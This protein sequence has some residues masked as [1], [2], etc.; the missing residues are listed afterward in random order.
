MATFSAEW[1]KATDELLS[2]RGVPTKRRPWDAWGE[3]SKLA[4]PSR[5]DSPESQAIFEWYTEEYGRERFAIGSLFTGALYFDQAV[6][7]VYV[8]I[9]YGT[10]SVSINKMV[11]SMP[12]LIRDRMYRHAT[13]INNLVAVGA[14]CIDYGLGFDDL[15]GGPLPCTLAMEM[16]VSADKELRSS[17]EILLSDRPTQKAAE[18]ARL[19]TEMFLKCFLAHHAGA[20]AKS[21]RDD[22]RH[23][24]DKALARCLKQLPQSDLRV[25]RGQFG[26]F[27]EIGDRYAV[28]ERPLRDLWTCYSLAQFA[29]ACVVRSVTD[30]DVR[31]SISV[32]GE[33]WQ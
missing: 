4:G 11:D 2:R 33:P 23:R 1:I 5:M 21:L 14:D 13:A 15:R 28:R 30:R 24:L 19:A 18:A 9:C 22:V 17:V 8:P 7:P 32:N 26:H 16:L 6:W 25:L 29:G 10:V 31:R 12:Q 27:P 3:W 20:S